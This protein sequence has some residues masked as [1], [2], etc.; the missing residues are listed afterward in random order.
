M[1]TSKL[2]NSWSSHSTSLVADTVKL[3][4][5]DDVEIHAARTPI[6]AIAQEPD[7]DALIERLR[8]FRGL[9]PADFKFD[10]EAVSARNY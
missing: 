1:E 6:F 5:A 3:K 8:E 7:K 2:G 4:S 10:R 9:M